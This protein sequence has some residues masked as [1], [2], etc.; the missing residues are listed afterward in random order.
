MLLMFFWNFM[1]VNIISNTRFLWHCGK[2][3]PYIND[4]KIKNKLYVSK[5]IRKYSHYLSLFLVTFNLRD[6]NSDPHWGHH[7][8]VWTYAEATAACNELSLRL[9]NRTDL[10]KAVEE[11]L[12]CCKDTWID[13]ERKA[14]ISQTGCWGHNNVNFPS[15]NPSTLY[16]AYCSGHRG[17]LKIFCCQY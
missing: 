4:K 2:Y 6:D 16:R 17:N 1:T 14:R 3:N 7:D 9:A 5:L 13:G 15:R 8:Q 10:L 11:G 12:D